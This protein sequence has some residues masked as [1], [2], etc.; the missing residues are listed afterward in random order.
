MTKST[1]VNV[2]LLAEFATEGGDLSRAAMSNKLMQDGLKG[3][4][5]LQDA[6]RDG[7]RSEVPV[8]LDLEYLGLSFSI[9]GR[10]DGLNELADPPVVEEIKTA[11]RDV[12]EILED[13]YPAHWAQ[14]EIYGYMI[15]AASGVPRITVRLVYHNLG[16]DSVRFTRTLL[17]EELSARFFSYLKPYAEWTLKQIEWEEKSVPTMRALAFPFE[18]YRK[19]QREMAA[20][21]YTALKNGKNLLCQAPTGIGKTAAALYPAIKALG[22]GQLEA[23]FYLT[24]R[25][26]GLIAAEDALERMRARG[27]ALRSVTL[28]ARDKI[29][30]QPGAGCDP[31][32]CP[33]ARGYF[34]RRRAALYEAMDMQ[35]LNRGTIEQLAMKYTLCPFE[36]SLDLSE[37][38]DTVIGDYNY[39][40]D[41]AVKLKRYFLDGGA[42]A[43]LV[44]EAHN[45]IGRARDFLSAHLDQKMVSQ[46]RRDVGKSAGRNSGLYKSLTNLLNAMKAAVDGIEEETVLYECPEALISAVESF[47]D[48]SGAFMD[49][50][51]PY[52]PALSDL[53]FEAFS[54][55]RTHKRYSD[56]YRTLVNPQKSGALFKLWCYDPSAYLKECM[57]RV[58]GSVLFSATLSPIGFYAESLGLKESDGDALLTLESPFPPENLLV[59][60]LN[61]DTRYRCRERTAPD[62]ARAILAMCRAKAGNYLA[63]FPSYAYLRLVQEYIEVFGGGDV[64]IAV[65]GSNMDEESREQFIARFKKQ[66]GKPLLALVAMGGVFAEGI[67]LPGEMLIG[68][69]IVGVGIPQIGFERD[70]LRELLNDS[71]QGYAYAYVYPGLERVLQAAGRVI[72]TE[73]DRGCVLLID[74]RFGRGEYPDLLPPHY[75]VKP[76]KSIQAVEAFLQDFWGYADACH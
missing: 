47:A 29:C 24:A 38:A 64:D 9:F 75:H 15:A 36:L 39:A 16:G 50:A 68:A 56:K 23:I 2:R 43:L 25:G 34:D 55:L 52:Y 69:A 7:A 40:F 26:T 33:H 45:L 12:N 76:V 11:A 72:R 8:R 17:K 70:A 66:S 32:I 51:A 42:Y 44:D 30:A 27:L 35:A 3:H 21:A 4:R 14:A 19:G 48:E 13:D 31:D 58:K 61:L 74:E 54:F 63:C 28:T 57:D 20:N 65:Q 46:L 67:D 10:I 73:T 59:L 1:R 6:Y 22:E 5:E 18:G 60:R 49:P 41:P 53:S 37:S 71:D 62:V